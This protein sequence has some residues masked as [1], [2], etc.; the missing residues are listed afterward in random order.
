MSLVTPA[1]ASELLGVKAVT[2][3]QQIHRKSFY[4]PFF[5][6]IDGFYYAKEIDLVTYK[7]EYEDIHKKR[8]KNVTVPFD[9]VEFARIKANAGGKSLGSYIRGRVL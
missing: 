1:Q 3:Y 5:D 4:G 2:I 6:K 9:D 7:K 8:C